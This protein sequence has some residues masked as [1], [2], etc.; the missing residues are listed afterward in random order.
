MR[1]ISEQLR[2][3]ERKKMKQLHKKIALNMIQ[4]YDKVSVK[5]KEPMV[6]LPCLKGTS[7]P[8]EKL[9]PTIHRMKDSSLIFADSFHPLVLPNL[10]FFNFD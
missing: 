10:E 3:R 2:E 8:K 6:L 1:N 5:F 9:K 7:H 4:I